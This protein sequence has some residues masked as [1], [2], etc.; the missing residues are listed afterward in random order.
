MTAIISFFASL[1]TGALGFLTAVTAKEIALRTAFVAVAVGFLAVVYG[2]LSALISSTVAA[3]P[4]IL[5]AP[6]S[7]VVP[8]NFGAC[9]TAYLGAHLA[10]YVYEWKVGIASKYAG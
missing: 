3:L 8:D 9:V 4:V 2:G 6:I 5:T 10:I 1:L 7:W